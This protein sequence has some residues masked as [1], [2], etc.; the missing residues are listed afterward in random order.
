[1]TY[2]AALPIAAN[3]HGTLRNLFGFGPGLGE[4]IA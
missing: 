4:A 2:R 1:M 3:P